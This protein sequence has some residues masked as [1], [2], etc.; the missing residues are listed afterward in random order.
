VTA[1]L[2][3]IP[4]SANPAAP[5]RRGRH[6]D[7]ALASWRRSEAVRLRTAG[8]SYEQVAQ[9]LGYANRGTVHR[10][11]QQALS[12]READSV[13]EL[14][15]LELARLDDVQ[16]ALWPRMMAGEVSAALGVLRV[17]DQRI[18]LLG[19]EP[20]RRDRPVA[21][22][23][24]SCHGPSTVVVHPDDCRHLGCPRHGKFERLPERA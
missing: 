16:A 22:N 21:D 4:T 3:E 12:A 5:P 23:W 2:L 14:R 17:I 6:R 1:A 10:I 24:P 13:D 11:V 20:R 19:L 8:L 9:E 7:Q 15:H 18:R